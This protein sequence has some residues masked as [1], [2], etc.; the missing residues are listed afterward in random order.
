MLSVVL[1]DVRCVLHSTRLP[2][3]LSHPGLFLL[4]LRAILS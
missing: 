1:F 2:L 3:C 4:F